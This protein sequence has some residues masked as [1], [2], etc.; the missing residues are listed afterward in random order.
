M[1]PSTIEVRVRHGEPM[2]SEGSYTPGMYVM[3]ASTIEVRVRHGEP[4][5]S[6]GSYTPGMYVMTDVFE[7]ADI[8]KLQFEALSVR[9]FSTD[10]RITIYP[11]SVILEISMEERKPK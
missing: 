1:N 10:N 6:E 8:N 5:A 9:I 11:W 4:M 2:A 7:I 3:T